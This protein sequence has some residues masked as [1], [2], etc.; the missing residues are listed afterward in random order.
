M[1]AF[2]QAAASGEVWKPLRRGDNP[3]MNIHVSYSCAGQAGSPF[4]DLFAKD[5]A[6]AIILINSGKKGAMVALGSTAYL[7]LDDCGRMDAIFDYLYK[8]ADG[9][10]EKFY[11]TKLTAANG[12]S[13][14]GRG[15]KVGFLRWRDC[16]W[17]WPFGVG[18]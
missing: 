6:E 16:F 3:P 14:F 12:S 7:A 9:F 10:E 8:C 13:A 4:R 11:S 1:A 17:G 15:K 2:R 18:L 5:R